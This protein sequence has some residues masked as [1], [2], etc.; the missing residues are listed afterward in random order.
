MS[1]QLVRDPL[2]HLGELQPQLWHHRLQH[3]MP[4]LPQEQ[5]RRLR[6]NKLVECY[7]THW[8]TVS[9][10]PVIGGTVLLTETGADPRR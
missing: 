9:G 3:L 5:V 6:C 8:P 2:E 7:F 4:V 1:E 10:I